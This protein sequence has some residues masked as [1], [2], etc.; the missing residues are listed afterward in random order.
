V[1][2][3]FSATMEL[4]ETHVKTKEYQLDTQV[5]VDVIAH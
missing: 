4:M 2:M 5:L 1:S 3:L